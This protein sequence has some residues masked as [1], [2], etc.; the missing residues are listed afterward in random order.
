M[1]KVDYEQAIKKPFTDIAKLIIGIVLSI[2]PII[3]WLAKGF[4]L[5]CSGVGKTKPSKKMPEFKEWWYLF[6]RGFASDIILVI[7][8]IPAILVFIIGAG[9]FIGSLAQGALIPEGFME[10][11]T[12]VMSQLIS[13]DWY[14]ALPTLVQL[15][16]IMIVGFIL[17]LVAVYLTPIA[18]LNY[19]KTK[20]FSEAFN[21]SKI[22]KK[23]FTGDYFINWL[24][25]TVITGII[26][27]ILSIIPWIGPGIALFVTGVIG[28]SIY[29]QVFRKV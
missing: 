1:A 19:L 14:L 3:H 18:V 20:K 16:P 12:E 10:G 28:Y 7:Y 24:I 21:F 11:E 15:A 2:I 5:E 23:A 22:I 17:F 8:A 29:G 6:I 9:V 26:T 13:Q 25:V 4:T 27:F